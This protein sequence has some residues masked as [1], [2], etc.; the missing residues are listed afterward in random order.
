MCAG[1][2][3]VVANL[4]KE[5]PTFTGDPFWPCEKPLG[6]ANKNRLVFQNALKVGT[7]GRGIE[8]KIKVR[9]C[10]K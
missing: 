5:S 10:R 4:A 9:E 7:P 6:D 1:A 8:H 2:V 3:F